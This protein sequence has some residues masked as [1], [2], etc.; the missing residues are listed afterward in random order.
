MI[1]LLVRCYPA[2]WRARYG[3]EFAA[4]LEE[5][6]LSPFDVADVLLGALDAHLHLRGHGA[7]SE[8]RK[9]FGMSLRIG[10][11]AAIGGGLLW[12]LALLGATGSVALGGMLLL[13]VAIVGLSSFQ[14]RRD[15]V[16]V[17]TALAVATVGGVA[18]S[19]GING[20][21]ADPQGAATVGGISVWDL[22]NV[23]AVGFSAGSSLFAIATLRTRSLPPLAA[24][25][26]AGCSL[27]STA[28][29]SAVITPI[30]LA[31]GLAEAAVLPLI[32]GGVMALAVGWIGF[33]IAVVRRDLQAM[34]RL[35]GAA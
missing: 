21:S 31:I 7:A 19:I 34:P 17:W 26:L 25:L 13:F 1:A 24:A 2:R 11:W 8:H 10:G 33:G 9:G 14:A 16:L 30:A 27:V 12:I 6:P 4:L 32:Y 5:R 35:H 29:L 18:S 20:M 23:G 22:F 15:P 28:A 3:D